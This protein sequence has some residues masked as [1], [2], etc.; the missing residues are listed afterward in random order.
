MTDQL[1]TSVVTVLTA[2]IGVAILAVLVSR[3]SNTSGVL[4]AG[5]SAF[6]GILGTALGPVSGQGGRGFSFGGGGVSGV[7][8]PGF[9]ITG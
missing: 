6:S 4:S 2:I 5:G 7:Q 3:Q 8:I 1:I 9:N